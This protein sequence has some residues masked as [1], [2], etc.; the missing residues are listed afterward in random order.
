MYKWEIKYE[1][2][3]ECDF[4]TL[5]ADTQIEAKEAFMQLFNRASIIYCKKI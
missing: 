1:Y 3:D 2:F 4:Y 5:Y